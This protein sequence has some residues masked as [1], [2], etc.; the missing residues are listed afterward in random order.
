MDV[1]A[2][3]HFGLSRMSVAQWLQ[4]RVKAGMLRQ[5]VAIVGGGKAA[6]DAINLLE[7]SGSLDIEIV[8]LFDDRDDNRSPA[9]VR[10][11]KKIGRITDLAE[12]R[13]SVA[14]GPDR[15]CHS[16]VCGRSAVAGVEPSVGTASR[17]PHLRT[18]IEAAVCAPSAYEYL[19]DLPMLSVFDRPLGGLACHSQGR[20]RPLD[21]QRCHRC[22]VAG[23][24]GDGCRHTAGVEGS[25]DLQAEAL[26]LQ[27]RACRGVEV[28]FNVYRHERCN[29]LQAGHP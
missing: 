1:A 2:R 5:R 12:L 6:E 10:T 23:D 15:C 8:G 11:H 4:P 25:G 24:A 3:A 21:C 14:G 17:H 22:A 28:P 20:H 9:S 27:Q 26:W 13:A 7:R 19:G 16:A 18:V 29:R